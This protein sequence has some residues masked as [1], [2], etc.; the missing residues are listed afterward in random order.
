MLTDICFCLKCGT[1]WARAPFRLVAC[2]ICF[3]RST[4]RVC[5]HPRVGRLFPSKPE[6]SGWQLFCLVRPWATCFP[7]GS[8]FLSRKRIRTGLIGVEVPLTRVILQLS[9]Q[10]YLHVV[11][12]LVRD[13]EGRANRNQL[14]CGSLERHIKNNA[15]VRQVLR[16]KPQGK[17]SVS[18]YSSGTVTSR[19][20]FRRFKLGSLR[21]KKHLKDRLEVSVPEP[22]LLYYW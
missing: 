11:G 18:K 9:F 10:L 2:T 13:N 12:Q 20:I 8:L 15:S 16:L 22:Y 6:E 1:A 17:S 7:P 19:R 5:P 21:F 14:S 3:V 4:C